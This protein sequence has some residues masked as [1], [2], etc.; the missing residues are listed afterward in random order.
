MKAFVAVLA[1]IL[2]GLFFFYEKDRELRFSGP[3]MGTT[4]AVTAIS[5]NWILKKKLSSEIQARLDAINFC[6]ST[7]IPGSELSRFNAQET[8]A[9]IP[10]SRDLFDVCRAGQ[11]LFNLTG[12]AWDATVKPLVDMWGFSE[13]E[14][15]THAP[16]SREIRDALKRVGF[17]KIRLVTPNAIQKTDPDITL[18]LNSIGDSFGAEQVAKI[19]SSHGITRY[20]VEV[21]GEIITAGKRLDG[22]SWRVGIETAAVLSVTDKAISTS[23]DYQNVR[24]IDGVTYS[25]IIDPKTGFPT[26]TRIRRATVVADNAMMADGLS[27][28]LLVMPPETGIA[29]INSIPGAQAWIIRETR[30]G[31]FEHYTSAGFDEL[32]INN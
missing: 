19:L 16:S 4:Y 27:T 29:L 20:F 2:A 23:G 8:T 24:V 1:V 7:Y 18:D 28:A 12:G 17:E 22:K 3:T 25:H 26:Q 30:E 15:R 9:A 32:L 5:P 10:V 21:G 6:L 11:S 13:K 31:R 14:K